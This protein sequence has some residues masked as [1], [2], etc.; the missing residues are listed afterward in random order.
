MIYGDYHTHT[1]YSHGKGSIEENAMAAKDKGLRE[2]GITDHGFL[3]RSYNVR[4]MDWPFMIKEVAAARKKFPEINILLGLES[5][6]LDSYG[7]IDIQGD[8]LSDMDILVCGYHKY[9]HTTSMDEFFRFSMPVYMSGLLHKSS[10]KRI[11]TNT[12]AFIKAI[13]RHPIDIISHP[14]HAIKTDLK[15]LA[16]AAAHYGT[17]LELNGKKISFSAFDAHI[18]LEEGAQFIIDS[19]AHSSARVGEIS[20]PL[21]FVK[22]AQ[23][24]FSSIANWNKKPTFR[25]GGGGKNECV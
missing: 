13:E 11:V 25:G 18:M 24:P 20:K 12:D 17:F 19:D 2:L 10:A 8:D 7:N 16:R 6:L 23:I 15:Q 21:Q 3:H 14:N 9:T 5:N 1:V 4:R 22:E